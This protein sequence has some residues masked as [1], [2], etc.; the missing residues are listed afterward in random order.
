MGF[1]YG[2]MGVDQYLINI[3]FIIIDNVYISK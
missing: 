3:I 2:G 1:F